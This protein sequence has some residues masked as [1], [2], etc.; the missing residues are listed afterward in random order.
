MIVIS[1]TVGGVALVFQRVC[2]FY[3]TIVVS[4]ITTV[5]NVLA[6]VVDEQRGSGTIPKSNH[7]INYFWDYNDGIRTCYAW[8]GIIYSF[9]PHVGSD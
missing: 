8:V 3:V 5:G 6:G 4:R 9:L 2:G 1:T 7:L